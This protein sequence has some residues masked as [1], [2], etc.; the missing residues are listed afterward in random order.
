MNVFFRR[1]IPSDIK[2]VTDIYNQ[3][4]L[5]GNCTCDTDVFLPEQR[6]DWLLEHNNERY[7]LF[8]CE[9]DKTIAGYGYLSAYRP[10]RKAVAHVAEVSYYLDFSQHRKGLGTV[11][12]QFLIEQAR[13]RGITDLIAV[14]LESNDASVYLLKK[15]GFELWGCLPGIIHLNDKEINHVIYG[16]HIES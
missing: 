2:C 11:F 15:L 10:G 8:V 7:P 6:M 16:L 9:V 13:C 4:I 12:L 14:L 1:A 5:S 3:A